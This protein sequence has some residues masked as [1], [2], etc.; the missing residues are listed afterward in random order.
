MVTVEFTYMTHGTK[1]LLGLIYFLY[2]ANE[3]QQKYLKNGVLNA[4]QKYNS[5]HTC[6]DALLQGNTHY[7]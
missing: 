1:G 6:D 4:R 3:K 5:L 2:K 7:D